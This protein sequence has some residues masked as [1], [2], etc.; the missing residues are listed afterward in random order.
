MKYKAGYKYKLDGTMMIYP[1]PIIPPDGESRSVDKWISLSSD[2]VLS[3]CDG[4][5]W[6]GASFILFKWFGTPKKWIRPSLAHDAL[7]QLAREGQL[8]LSMRK[9]FDRVFYLL[10]R[11]NKLSWIVAKV[12]YYAVRVGGN[13]ALRHGTK[14]QEA[15]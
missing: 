10:L 12:A 3:I 14:T 1:S 7:Y 15:P 6:D 4:Y 5:A 2:K 8:P 13:Y 11:E 9:Q